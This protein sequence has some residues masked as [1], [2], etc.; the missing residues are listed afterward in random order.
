[1]DLQPYFEELHQITEVADTYI[2]TIKESI[3]KKS[4][5]LGQETTQSM[6][7]RFRTREIAQMLNVSESGLYKAEREGRIPKAHYVKNAA[8]RLIRDG[9]SLDHL[10]EIR[11]VFN[12]LPALPADRS[13]MVLSFPN[14]KGGCWKTSLSLLASQYF[15]IKGYRVLLIDTDAQGTLSFFMGYQPDI[16]TGYEDTI[17]PYVLFDDAQNDRYES[18]AYALKPTK[19]PNIDIIPANL[20]LSLIDTSLPIALA[21][22]A[23]NDEKQEL[24]E[25]LGDGIASVASDYD[26]VIVDGTPS[27]NIL[28]IST[29]MACDHVV[30]PCPSQ[31]ADFAST[32]QFFNN[33]K[34]SVSAF[35]TS[36]M[37]VHF[38]DYHILI[39][40]Y[41]SA[42]YSNWMSNI[43]RKTFGMRTLDNVVKKSDEIGKA[44]TQITTIYEKQPSRMKNR[45]SLD[46]AVEMYDGVFGEIEK[47]IIE[48]FFDQNITQAT[49]PY[50][51]EEGAI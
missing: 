39:T 41:A 12:R 34:N 10:L 19:W 16:D 6:A 7:R 15:A 45:R 25:R 33:L 14:L 3:K 43:V 24:V 40:K 11:R 48:P 1:M 44:G 23:S 35:V 38:P 29:L 46:N 21:S 32:I 17:A 51:L 42:Q 2:K 31:M 37:D 20:N 18:L 50:L 47:K 13:A 49:E 8:G 9:W 5:E 22:A 36:G 26:L 27:L 4:V 30:V 28:T